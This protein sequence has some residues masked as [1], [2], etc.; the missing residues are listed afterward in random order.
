MAN[1][2]TSFAR[3]FISVSGT[4][5]DTPSSETP[6]S[7]YTATFSSS[8]FVGDSVLVYGAFTGTDKIIPTISDAAGNVFNLIYSTTGSPVSAGTDSSGNAVNTWA[9]SVIYAANINSLSSP[10]SITVNAPSSTLAKFPGPGEAYEWA[11]GS[12]GLTFFAIAQNYSTILQQL[13]LT[14]DQ[15]GLWVFFPLRTFN[16]NIAS[17]PIAFSPILG[18]LEGPCGVMVSEG[19]ACV[20]PPETIVPVSFLFPLPTPTFQKITRASGML[21]NFSVTGRFNPGRL[22]IK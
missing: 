3:N 1:A 15:S 7:S 2:V 16:D 19:D 13:P 18:I 17:S 6:P 12:V 14:F 8:L 10:Y 22:S 4:G 20:F 5:W 11:G 9:S 21:Q